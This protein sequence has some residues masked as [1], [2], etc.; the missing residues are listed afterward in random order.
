MSAPKTPAEW[1][2][3]RRTFAGGVPKTREDAVCVFRC[4]LLSLTLGGQACAKRHRQAIAEAAADAKRSAAKVAST[5]RTYYGAAHVKC[6]RC[7]AGAA[8]L[9]LL[10]LR[11]ED[12]PDARPW[13][14]R[15][16]L[17]VDT[18]DDDAAA[19]AAQVERGEG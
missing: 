17:V 5:G 16:S 4:P 12:A 13:H 11:Q 8:R 1:L 9:R 14:R 3:T 18:F 6:V 2:A 10:G 7:E 15:T 19:L